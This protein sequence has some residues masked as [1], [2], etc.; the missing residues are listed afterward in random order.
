MSSTSGPKK[1]QARASE[2]QRDA[3][4]EL[5]AM[6]QASPIPPDEL[7]VNLALYMRSSVLAKVLYVDELYRKIVK[8]PGVI[9]E[10][11]VWWGANLAL[12]QSLRGIHEPYN[13]TRKVIGFDTFEG[14]SQPVVQDGTHELVAAGQYAVTEQYIK[15]LKR[16][17]GYHET[18]NTMSHVQKFELV[19]GDATQS[20]HSYLEREPQT[21]VALAYFDMQLYEPTKA[22]LKAIRPHLVRGSVIALDEFASSEFP[23]ETL[24]LRESLGLDRYR[25]ERSQFLPDRTF[26]IVD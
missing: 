4:Q 17:L 13:W 6:F 19:R 8:V 2:I 18:E 10:F 5:I 24:A 15:Y 23:G 12:F 21:V 16:M 3:R 20:I 22:C 14:Y 7:M 9:M 1:L 25:L 11:G 26:L